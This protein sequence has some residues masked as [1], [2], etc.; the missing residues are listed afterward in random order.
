MQWQRNSATAPTAVPSPCLSSRRCIVLGWKAATP[1]PVY[2]APLAAGPLPS[3]L[4]L[5]GFA[6]FFAAKTKTHIKRLIRHPQMTGV[7][8]WSA[9]HLLTN[10]DS[11]SLALFGSFA[12]WSLLEIVLINRRDG[13]R[14]SL[15]EGSTRGDVTTLVIAIV[16]F[17]IFAFLHQRLFG[18]PAMPVG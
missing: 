16:V 4:V 14:T 6:L 1:S 8:L 9:A 2:A 15:P 12:A 13:P 5:C 11:R 10:G 18:V 3:L 17:A 7:F